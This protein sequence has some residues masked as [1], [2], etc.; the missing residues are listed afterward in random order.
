M[1]SQD[2]SI[3]IEQTVHAPASE[4][5]RAFTNA[6]ALREWLCDV[7]TTDPRPG[8]RFFIAW[9]NGD[10]TAGSFTKIDP[11]K[12]I[13]IKTHSNLDSTV[14]TLNIRLVGSKDQTRISLSE[15]GYGDS[16]QDND[17]KRKEW[18]NSLK[19]LVSVLEKGPDLRI[20]TR[21]LMGIQLDAFNEKV[22][23]ELGV[24]VCN[25]T[26]VLDVISGL[27]A[28]KAGLQ[29]N[30]VIVE[31]AGIPQVEFTDYLVALKGKVG[32]DVIKVVYYRGAEKI[33][34]D[35]ELSKRPIPEIPPT[36]L[37]L[38]EKIKE[39]QNAVDVEMDKLVLKLSEE[40]ANRRP[41]EKEWNTKEIIAHL[42]HY[43][44]YLQAKINDY[45]FSQEEVS[46]GYADNL[47]P[48]VQATA[49]VFGPIQ[50]IYL[51]FKRN[52][53]EIVELVRHLPEDFVKRKSTWWR[54]G[55]ILLTYCDH[56]R[57]HLN[58]IKI[59]SGS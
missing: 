12:E 7:A 18:Q 32:G 23:K 45:V 22:A 10:F 29:R 15:S 42:L 48:R 14:V 57:E 39:S 53:A 58:Q 24:P 50:D 56:T 21:P 46:D 54:M 19:N 59:A 44:R 17:E 3:A 37:E 34:A 36:A 43:E 30:D 31:L 28:Q 35:M 47:L 13:E 16:S 1:S 26:R 49:T 55:Y 40:A 41:A 4:V 51:E 5:F 2:F 25:G 6:T 9:N 8:G 52:Q 33:I 20:T 11:D 27:G 38:A